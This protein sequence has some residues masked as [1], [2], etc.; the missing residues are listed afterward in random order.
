MVIGHDV[1][2]KLLGLFTI[3]GKDLGK[4]GGLVKDQELPWFL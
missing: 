1:E 2:L 4:R 3:C